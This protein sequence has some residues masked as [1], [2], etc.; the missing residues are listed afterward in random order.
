MLCMH[1]MPCIVVTIMLVCREAYGPEVD[2]YSF[3]IVLW[4]IATQRLPFE[5]I[6]FDTA[7]EKAILKPW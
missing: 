4:E 7:V 5:S 2:V 6:Q 3:G 1:R